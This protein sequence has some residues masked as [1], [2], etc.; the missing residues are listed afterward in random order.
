MTVAGTVL[1]L[2]TIALAALVLRVFLRSP[3]GS[4]GAAGSWLTAG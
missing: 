4:P 3:G 1:T 2:A